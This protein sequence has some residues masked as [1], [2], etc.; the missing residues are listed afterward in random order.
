MTATAASFAPGGGQRLQPLLRLIE[1]L[2]MLDGWMGVAC[3]VALVGLM[4][5]ELVLRTLS[6][7]FPAIPSDIPV[8]WEYCSYLMAATFTFGAAMTLRT[9]GHVRVTLLVGHLRGAWKDRLELGVSLVGALAFGFLTFAMARFTWNSL[10]TGQTSVS[11]GTLLWVPQ[12]V[13]TLGMALLTLQLVAR[14]LQAA[15]RLPLEDHALRATD[16]FE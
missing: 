4:L 8:A 9:G 16:S 2:T 6:N 10:T 12:S 5:L 7:L 1:R 15:L 14:A 11:S 3:L 13:V